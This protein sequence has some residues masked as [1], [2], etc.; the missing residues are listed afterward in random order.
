MYKYR[1]PRP[2]TLGAVETSEGE[3]IEMKIR[4]IVNNKE[5]ITDGA[6]EIFTERKDGV[7]PAYNI[8]T[9]RWEIAVDAMDYVSRSIDAKRDSKPKMEVIKNDEKKDG[10]TEPAQGNDEKTS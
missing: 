4:R 9:D 10:G 2:T 1:K 3:T 5:A 8:R 6:P 7:K